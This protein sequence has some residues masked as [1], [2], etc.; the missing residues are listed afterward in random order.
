MQRE[1]AGDC[2]HRHH[3]HH[4]HHQ[5]SEDK[6]KLEDPATTMTT[7]T[8][9]QMQMDTPSA[10]ASAA[11][12]TVAPTTTRRPLP[13]VDDSE[14]SARRQRSDSANSTDDN[15]SPTDQS[16]ALPAQPSDS[17]V[18]P[19]TSVA[20]DSSNFPSLPP[21]SSSSAS[22]AS[23][24]DSSFKGAAHTLDE[25]EFECG[26]CLSLL[27]EP[28][29]IP[30]GHTYCQPCL[31]R[32]LDV[33]KKECPTCRSPCH[34][35]AQ[36]MPVNITL[37]NIIRKYFPEQYAK[38]KQWALE[39]K[40]DWHTRLS[41]F[42]MGD[43]TFPCGKI[44][45]RLFEPRYLL[46]ARRAL[47]SDKR[48]GFMPGVLPKPGDIGVV[49]YIETYD[50]DADGSALVECAIQERFRL[51]NC[52]QEHGTCGL[53]RGQVELFKDN[54]MA[55]PPVSSNSVASSCLKELVEELKSFVSRFCGPRFARQH[56]KMPAFSESHPQS[57]EKLS[58]YFAA[59][60]SSV[61]SGSN[62]RELME[63]QSTGQR[64]HVCLA[65][66]RKVSNDLRK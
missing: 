43:V 65:I 33:A 48:F 11:T 40:K 66:A 63:T 13:F 7:T 6:A 53:I 39:E 8:A 14:R 58:F 24:A 64:L 45:L 57:M 30:C 41:I 54:P 34:I 55:I 50:Y 28:I 61:M 4:H 44:G 19:S 21:S 26:L 15:M 12:S 49:L 16:S 60:L 56:G 2:N 31:V 27:V 38:R 10:Y 5:M 51:V 32:A 52:W 20:F 23:T 62:K 46:M 1:T 3:H 47:A 35:E 25:S 42:F 9:M 29:S 36:Q 22:A 59:A 18:P 17:S 37:S